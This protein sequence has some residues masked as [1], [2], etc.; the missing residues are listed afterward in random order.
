MS[1]P[2]GS[3]LPCS[4]GVTSRW[5][6]GT[7][8]PRA[9]CPRSR[10]AE[11]I[12]SQLGTPLALP[13]ATSA[14][15]W[16]SLPP[17]YRILHCLWSLA[18]AYLGCLMAGFLVAIPGVR[19]AGPESPSPRDRKWWRRPAIIGLSGFGRGGRGRRGRTV[20]DARHLG[21]RDLHADLRLARAGL[22]RRRLQPGPGPRDLARGGPLRIRLPL[23]DLRMAFRPGRL[24]PS[25]GRAADRRDLPSRRAAVVQRAPRFRS[26]DQDGPSAHPEEAGTTDPDALPRRDAPG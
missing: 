5:C 6:T 18:L 21:R 7:H 1:G 11:A 10:L 23:P 13:P 20:V 12:G 8:S 2:V 3:D 9:R 26:P 17:N 14:E 22:P 15:G 24:A 25:A 19:A 4:A 16:Y